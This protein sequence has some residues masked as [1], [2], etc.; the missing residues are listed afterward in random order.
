MEIILPDHSPASHP[1]VPSFLEW[2]F[3]N[4]GNRVVAVY[5]HGIGFDHDFLPL[6]DSAY[7]GDHGDHPP[8]RFHVI[9]HCTRQ[10]LGDLP[11]SQ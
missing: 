1:P 8:G 7:T 10:V 4:R 9:E 2:C 11:S 3:T 5:A 6:T